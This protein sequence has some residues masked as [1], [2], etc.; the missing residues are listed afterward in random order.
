MVTSN[1]DLARAHLPRPTRLAL[2]SRVAPVPNCPEPAGLST[3][4]FEM[5]TSDVPYVA[6]PR[7]RAPSPRRPHE[8]AAKRPL[9][10]QQVPGPREKGGI[11]RSQ[12]PQETETLL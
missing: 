1:R 8:Q 9:S 10:G 5:I 3:H 2:A 7:A 4:Q 11:G 6:T 12:E